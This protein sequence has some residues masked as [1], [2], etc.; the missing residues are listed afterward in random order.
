M[1]PLKN[2]YYAFIQVLYAFFDNI[3]YIVRIVIF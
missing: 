1:I 3:T 2:Y